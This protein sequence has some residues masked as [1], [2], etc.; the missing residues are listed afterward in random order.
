MLTSRFRQNQPAVLL[1]LFPLV[2]ILWPGSAPHMAQPLDM[3]PKGMPL[4]HAFRAFLL[5]S[6]WLLPVIGG[7]LVIVLCL[8]LNF[9]AN[10]SELYERRNH[11]PA[12]LLPLLLALM[13]QGFVPDPALVGMP[14]VLWAL[15][16][17]WA[18]QAQH[19]ILGALFD[20]GMLSGMA[21]LFH[22]PYA[23]L[24]VVIWAS[25]AVMRPFN[26]R[27]Y[28]MPV[29]GVATIFFFAWGTMQLFDLSMDTIRSLRPSTSIAGQVQAA[30]W[31][32]TALRAVVLLVFIGAGA[33]SFA[34]AY[35]R[36]VMREKNTRASF[37]SFVFASALLGAFGWLINGVV[38]PIIVA[39]PLAVFLSW[40]LLHARKIR[41][42]EAGVFALLGL[43][44]WA[45]WM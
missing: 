3:V 15:R 44:I 25:L 14:F 29:V 18:S 13:P 39:V 20:A 42:A 27:E 45:R 5:L 34:K 30:H 9:T 36:G 32:F 41:W 28:L 17:L 4:Y 38:P 1:L 22:L 43:A 2:A 19:R 33:M 6:P 40:P 37:L 23:F 8:Q 31:F 11:L 7:L 21:A 35:G 24:V 26:W 12:L 16:R 10:E